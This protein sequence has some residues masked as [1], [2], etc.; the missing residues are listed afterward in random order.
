VKVEIQRLDLEL[1]LPKHQ[2]QDD[3]GC[4]LYAGRDAVIAANGGR[5]LISTGI[6]IAVPPGYAAL[7]LPRSGLAHKH[8]IT[9]LNAPG[10]IDSQYRGEIKVLLL[11]TDPYADYAV[12]RG[13]R[14]AQLLV[15][16]VAEMEWVE[17]EDLSETARGESG[18]GST[19]R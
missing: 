3:A 2:H 4:D 17:V 15:T 19:G 18:F 12:S 14:I 8:G 11:N 6:A 1:P 5:E 16:P 10:L 7:V 13:D 9:C